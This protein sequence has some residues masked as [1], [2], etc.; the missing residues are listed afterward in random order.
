MGKL[1]QVL[2]LLGRHAEAD[3]WLRR[4]DGRDGGVALS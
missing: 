4:I 3:R 2:Q 1:A